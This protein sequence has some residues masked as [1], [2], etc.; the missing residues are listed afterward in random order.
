MSRKTFENNDNNK[1]NKI[2]FNDGTSLSSA[3]HVENDFHVRK[4]L[5]VSYDTNL[6]SNLYVD[7]KI[8]GQFAN[9]DPLAK[10]YTD[11]RT[12][13]EWP[14]K[15]TTYSTIADSLWAH[16]DIIEK[17]PY[18]TQSYVDK[19]NENTLSFIRKTGADT[20]T[21][22][23]FSDPNS[24]YNIPVTYLA[25]E[26][27]LIIRQ[28][29][30]TTQ[31]LKI[32]IKG[33]TQTG[34]YLKCLNEDGDITWGDGNFNLVDGDETIQT[35][36]GQ[37]TNPS[38]LIKDLGN[39]SNIVHDINYYLNLPNNS[40]DKNKLVSQNSI[41]TMYGRTQSGFSSNSQPPAIIGV[42]SLGSEGIK[43]KSGYM[44]NGIYT[45]GYTLIGG[46][47]Q[48]YKN[49]EILLSES[50]IHTASENYFNHWGKLLISSRKNDVSDYRQPP[51]L[52]YPD[53]PIS[54]IKAELNVGSDV[55][56]DTLGITKLYG[57]LFIKRTVGGENLT[58]P[59]FL[60]CIQ[61]DGKS[62]F[63]TLPINYILDTDDIFTIDGAISLGNPDKYSFFYGTEIKLYGPVK[64]QEE[65]YVQGTAHLNRVNIDDD[66]TT[67]G[68]NSFNDTY[69]NGNFEFT[70]SGLNSK[71]YLGNDST[72]GKIK[73]IKFG[74]SDN[75]SD[76][77]SINSP[78]EF[79]NNMYFING[80][81]LAA[82]VGA[83][84]GYA[85]GNS[86]S[87]SFN[88]TKKS[89][90]K[91]NV[92]DLSTTFYWKFKD[93][94]NNINYFPF[95][96]NYN[97][98]T[99]SVLS[100]GK[101][102][103]PVADLGQFNNN[104]EN[105]SPNITDVDF[106]K[107]NKI[108]TE[109]NV[110]YGS[111]AIPISQPG[112]LRIA[113]KCYYRQ[114]NSTNQNYDTPYNGDVLVGIGG[115]FY[116]PNHPNE[117]YGEA[118][119]INIQDIL[120]TSYVQDLKFEGDVYIGSIIQ[121]T[122]QKAG[123]TYTIPVNKSNL[124][125]NGKIFFRYT[126]T[127]SIGTATEN[128]VLT[129]VDGTTG[130]VQWRPAVTSS[131]TFSS[132]S[133]SGV[134][135]FEGHVYARNQLT[136][137]GNFN[138]YNNNSPITLSQAE[139]ITLDGISSNIQNQINN[140]LSL[141]GG[142]ISG[143]TTFQN[144]IKLSNGA[145]VN[146]YLKCTNSDGTCE[147]S[148][149][150]WTSLGDS[151]ENLTVTN[152]FK[153]NNLIKTN[154]SSPNTINSSE[155]IYDAYLFSSDLTTIIP[156]NTTQWFYTTRNTDYG[157]GFNNSEYLQFG[158]ITVPANNKNN[159]S[160]S[161]PIKIQH[162]WYYK[163]NL[164][165]GDEL[166]HFWYYLDNINILITKSDNTIIRKYSIN[167]PSCTYILHDRKET[168]SGPNGTLNTEITYNTT[169]MIHDIHL[170][171]IY[172]NVYFPI[173]S[174]TETYKLSYNCKL[175]WKNSGEYIKNQSFL[176][177]SNNIALNQVNEN[178]LSYPG[179]NVSYAAIPSGSN[180]TYKEMLYRGVRWNCTYGTTP[181]LSDL[182]VS[183]NYIGWVGVTS[184]YNNQYNFTESDQNL[185]FTG[186][187]SLEISDLAISNLNAKGNIYSY[188]GVIGSCGFLCRKGYPTLTASVNDGITYGDPSNQSNQYFGT[189]SNWGSIFN[190]WWD[191]QFK[192]YIDYSHI[193][194]L[195][196]NT[197]DYR[198]KHNLKNLDSILDKI[199]SIQLYSY[200]KENVVDHS[201]EQNHIGFLA[202]QIQETFPEY[203][204]LISGEK[205]GI[206]LQMVNYNEITILLMKSIQELSAE[207]KELKSQLQQQNDIINALSTAQYYS[208]KK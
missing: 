67:T 53:G 174:T 169:L 129:C 89:G 23:T 139:L 42:Y 60:K 181:S 54:L 47:S 176:F 208:S 110:I 106:Y 45:S 119:W 92:E 68:V 168:F 178:F 163:D 5:R 201:I 150:N 153:V 124:N 105:I 64:C 112:E 78:I 44:D 26:N 35:N 29:D 128:Y 56:D 46:G 25:S 9:L 62:E 184:G 141:S 207:I 84:I 52:N 6:N 1:I 183:S 127:D 155:N 162:S 149:L 102:Y 4:K 63:T 85:I 101:A 142:V 18:V 108:I 166:S 28:D 61:T 21:Y 197:S 98:N 182:N 113:G 145:I 19:E 17:A 104:E 51:N 33:Q 27:A 86:G 170:A 137:Y 134:S 132:L 206:E 179:Y 73:W 80:G 109:P 10:E 87:G 36:F 79:Y 172:F 71:Y 83:G 117:K 196:P 143:L 3:S 91:Y 198:I 96:I 58:K 177:Y 66:L 204:H 121:Y 30:S 107:D 22:P 70:S 186:T 103:P 20:S 146:K 118:K 111:T 120:P 156:Y 8:Y 2:N 131:G 191:G 123:V 59:L 76:P 11:L 57:E 81:Y 65:I 39:G 152:L 74:K 180:T 138:L 144:S 100:I 158:T 140:K 193:I 192:I 205:D 37:S 99:A 48:S 114:W 12:G 75:P 136:L 202:H 82:G 187:Q 151:T 43:F 199:N 190:T 175:K 165:S 95:R 94:Q 38:L 154:R 147:W 135:T 16:I 34:K 90:F 173:L 97:Q 194:T 7:G 49:Q 41:F 116:S 55:N 69:I 195:S 200:D 157:W 126:N 14:I 125:I 167:R 203:D 164:I 161:F 31:K 88:G 159:L 115:T 160:I 148:D 185:P 77:I 72:T 24:N 40:N 171:N 130:E 13:W 50:G 32:Q 133:V 189:S 122:F 93:Q 188:Y 15:G